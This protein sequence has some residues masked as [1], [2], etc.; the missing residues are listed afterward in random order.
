MGRG[1][2]SEVAMPKWRAPEH[3]EEPVA[4]RGRFESVT[5]A[6]Q[7]FDTDREVRVYLPLGYD[8]GDARYPLLLVNNGIQDLEL[9]LTDRSL[10]NLVGPSVAP[11]VVAFIEV[12]SL[13]EQVGDL[14]DDFSKMVVEEIVPELDR[15]FRTVTDASER[16]FMG[17]FRGGTVPLYSAFKYPDV[18][19]KLGLQTYNP[20]ERLEPEIQE[21]IQSN[22]NPG[23]VVYLDWGRYAFRSKEL[24]AD[25]RADGMRLAGWLEAASIDLAG[26]EA[27]EGDGW[28]SWRSRTDLLLQALYPIEE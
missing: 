12:H 28:G 4:T 26:G 2:V 23:L 27:I 10:D 22:A 13:G 18:F 16:G 24:G 1:D 25:L 8:D 7:Y 3:L 20:V 15:R 6:S 14:V 21:M 9:A 11:I 19:G 5:I 17:R